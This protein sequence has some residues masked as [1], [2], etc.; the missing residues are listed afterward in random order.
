MSRIDID[1]TIQSHIRWRRQFHNAFADGAYAAMPLSEHRACTLAES[2]QKLAVPLG[3]QAE[4][5][6]L[7]RQHRRFH[8]L[9]REIVV[10]SDNGLG[11]SADL[12]LPELN[13]ACHQV[14]AGLDW[15]R[16][17]QPHLL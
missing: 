13:E 11:D 5:E 4:F 3:E 9:A 15:L 12:L 17:A 10:L 8:D 16:N 2:L 1:A 7:L 14:V 6:E